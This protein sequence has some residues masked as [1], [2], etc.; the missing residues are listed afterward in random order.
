MARIRREHGLGLLFL[1]RIGLGNWRLTRF[2]KEGTDPIRAGW[3]GLS[4]SSLPVAV[5]VAS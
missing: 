3:G 2:M 5:L 1:C 4:P